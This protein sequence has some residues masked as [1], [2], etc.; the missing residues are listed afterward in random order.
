MNASADDWY[1]PAVYPEWRKERPWV[2]Q[3]MMAIQ[4]SLVP[5]VER[6]GGTRLQEVAALLRTAADAGDPIVACGVGTAGHGARGV[7]VAL[8][9]ALARDATA[10]AVE[11]RESADQALAPRKGGVCVA[12]SH[13]G[14]SRS[15][16]EALAAARK[17]GAKTV[18]ITAAKDTPSHSEADVSVQLPLRDKSFC[19][20]VGYSTPIMVAL[21][22][23]ALAAGR[24]FDSAGVATYLEGLASLEEPAEQIGHN[25]ASIER[26][27]AAGSLVDEPSAR[28]LALDMAEA[29][30][31]PASVFGVED[32]LHGHLVAHDD[33]SGLGVIV[34]GGPN[35]RY[36]AETANSLLKAANRIGLHTTAILTDD[37][38]AQ[39]EESS[40]SAGRLVLPT[41]GVE[42]IIVSLLGGALALQHL[43][44]GCVHSKGTN[45]D[46]LRRESK[47]WREAV[48]VGQAKQS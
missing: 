4:A 41:A 18:L 22:A 40:T 17:A 1:D 35:V 27:I 30:W 39:V 26:F 19:H 47:P 11:F 10:R 38:A 37:I 13:G 31:I 6:S 5:E 44:M 23:G 9:D 15:T 12:V 3:D 8:N 24:T 42:P 34:T 25:L 2:M 45:P 21:I 29:A 28:E 36:A 7:A 43:S 32:V 14:R 46:L 33:N 16:V 48:V 20:T